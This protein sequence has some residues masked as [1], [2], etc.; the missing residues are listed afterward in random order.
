MRTGEEVEAEA[1]AEAE[2]EGDEDAEEEAA[3]AGREGA[4]VVTLGAAKMLASE[5]RCRS[6]GEPII[7]TRCTGKSGSRNRHSFAS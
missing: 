2:V 7:G 3:S 4:V 5:G 1:E 6:E